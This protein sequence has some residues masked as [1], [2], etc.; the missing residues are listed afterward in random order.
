M[1]VDGRKP[2]AGEETETAVKMGYGLRDMFRFLHNSLVN[3]VAT[4]SRV[5]PTNGEDN[6]EAFVK[7]RGTKAEFICDLCLHP[8]Q[9]LGPVGAAMSSP[10]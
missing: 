3:L 5:A 8:N 4:R 6:K 10:D 1:L 7:I 2:E 9:E